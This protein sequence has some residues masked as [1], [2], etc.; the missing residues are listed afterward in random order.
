MSSWAVP[1]PG[2][3]YRVFVK[4]QGREVLER[5]CSVLLDADAAAA[6]AAPLEAELKAKLLADVVALYASEAMRVFALAY[7]DVPGVGPEFH[8]SVDSV[9]KNSDG[10]PALSME[11][12]EGLSSTVEMVGLS[13]QEVSTMLEYIYS[14]GLPL[15]M[16]ACTCIGLLQIAYMYQMSGMFEVGLDLL[17]FFVSKNTV[18]DI[19]HGLAVYRESKPSVAHAFDEIKVWVR[20]DEDL[21]EAVCAQLPRSNVGC[22]DFP[23][24]SS[25][26]GTRTDGTDLNVDE[27]SKG[28]GC[29]QSTVEI[30]QEPSCPAGQDAEDLSEIPEPTEPIDF[31]VVAREVVGTVLDTA[32]SFISRLPQRSVDDSLPTLDENVIGGAPWDIEEVPA[33]IDERE[34]AHVADV[35]WACC[36]EARIAKDMAH[37]SE[38]DA[39]SCVASPA[40]AVDLESKSDCSGEG[41]LCC[42]LAFHMHCPAFRDALFRSDLG[43]ELSAR[44]E[45]M[46]PA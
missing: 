41:V 13:P 45:E 33:A 14:F 31:Q 34:A 22:A 30:V 43:A 16:D 8:E 24:S 28:D 1:L 4:G 7:R 39:S 32:S 9:V 10:S 6:D 35:Q 5:C 36:V 2:G 38:N 19:L 21:F 17:R 12:K 46:C 40:A 23:L 15:D 27:Q 18:V 44:G 11:C 26:S 42:D 20:K 3:G 29:H 37:G 25:S